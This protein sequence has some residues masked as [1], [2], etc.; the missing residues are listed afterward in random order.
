MLQ[1]REINKKDKGRRFSLDE[2]IA[3]LSIF[4]QSPK[5]YRFIRKIFILPAPQTLIKLINEANVKPGI[6]QNIFQQIKGAVAKLKIED[7]LCIILFD[8]V[9]LKANL[10]YNERRDHVIGFATDGE[11]I[12]T[13]FADHAQV[14][15]VRG[16]IRN[17]KQPVYYSFSSSATR[18]PDLAKQMKEVV[19]ELLDAGLIVI[20]SVCDQG[21]N[22]RNAIK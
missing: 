14:F 17:Y 1:F 22:N 8:E 7:R 2:K 3:S 11:T 21:T 12:K 5:C 19:M 18:G 4:K 9:S 15:M 6:N 13:D 10:T 16:L 20:G